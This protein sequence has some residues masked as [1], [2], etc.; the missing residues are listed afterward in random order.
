MNTPASYFD[1]QYAHTTDPWHLGERWYDR[2]KYNL[3]V[4]ALPR[5]RYPRAFEPGCSVGVLTELLAARCD[6]LLS[7]DRIASAVEATDQRTIGFDHVTVRRMT[8]PEQWPQD[9]FD[10]IV[11]SELLY[12]FDTTTRTRLLD[13]SVESLGEGGHL[14]TVHWNHPVAEHTCTGRDIADHLDTLTS[15]SRLARYDDPDFTLTVHEHSQ[16]M[17]PALSPACAEGLA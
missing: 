2:R 16:G 1:N 14:V 8:V 10:L 5:P 13:K 7:T 9:S 6:H 12:Y 3:T 15:L 17:R 11:L 4:A